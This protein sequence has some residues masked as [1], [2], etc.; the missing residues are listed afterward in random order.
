MTQEFNYDVAMRVMG[1]ELAKT[2]LIAAE[3]RATK[4]LVDEFGV[5]EKRAEAYAAA[6]F[7]NY[8]EAY[9]K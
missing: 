8:L 6:T 5:E 3:V 9:S 4:R 1:E 7:G 2:D